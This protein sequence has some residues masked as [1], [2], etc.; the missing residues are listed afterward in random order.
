MPNSDT[1]HACTPTVK[2]V[3]RGNLY[4]S[5]IGVKSVMDTTARNCRFV[6]KQMRCLLSYCCCC[7]CCTPDS[8]CPSCQCTPSCCPSYSCTLT[9]QS[10]LFTAPS[11]SVCF[12]SFKIVNGIKSFDIIDEKMN[13]PSLCP[14]HSNHPAWSSTLPTPDHYWHPQRSRNRYRAILLPPAFI[15]A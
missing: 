1:C 7:C 4:R 3:C 5:V 6:L 8:P 2:S 15:R 12:A 11:I 14:P 13:T 10:L 9:M